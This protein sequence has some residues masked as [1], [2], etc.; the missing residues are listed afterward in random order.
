MREREREREGAEGG[1]REE[2]GTLSW[3]GAGWGRGGKG[4]ARSR[5]AGRRRAPGAKEWG[6][7][8]AR[9]GEPAR[10]GQSRLGVA[11]LRI[12]APL[13]ASRR[14]KRHALRAHSRRRSGERCAPR[15]L[16]ARTRR[17]DT[18]VAV[19]KVNPGAPARRVREKMTSRTR[20][21]PPGRSR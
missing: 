8:R 14:V 7:E 3:R 17:R 16:T 10:L 5:G 15:A 18:H 12:V 19:V 2:R 6:G 4:C 11:R 13:S 20:E 1:E 9:L 21:L